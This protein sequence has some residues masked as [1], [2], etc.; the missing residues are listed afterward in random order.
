MTRR[1]VYT[2]CADA[3]EASCSAGGVLKVVL[4]GYEQRVLQ[5]AFT[6]CALSKFY[7]AQVNV[8]CALGAKF[9]LRNFKTQVSINRAGFKI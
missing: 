5:L 8:R 3:I 7:K 6:A 2:G 1:T 4:G 9:E